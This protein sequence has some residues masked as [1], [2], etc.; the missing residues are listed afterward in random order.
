[1]DQEIEDELFGDEEGVE[2]DAE[3]KQLRQE[4]EKAH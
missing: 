3:T 2:E 1:M 4:R